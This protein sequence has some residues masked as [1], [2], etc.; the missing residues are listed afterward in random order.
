MGNA[1]KS[2]RVCTPEIKKEVCLIHTFNLRVCGNQI[3]LI[4]FEIVEE[5]EQ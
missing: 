2:I 3:V 4:G 1:F 5:A